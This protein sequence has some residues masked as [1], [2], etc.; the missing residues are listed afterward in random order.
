MLLEM[1]FLSR[2]LS[3]ARKDTAEVLWASDVLKS[4]RDCVSLEV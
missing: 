4:R 1:T 2:E 3:A